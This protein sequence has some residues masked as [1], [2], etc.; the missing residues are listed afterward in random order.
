MWILMWFYMW[1]TA[2]AHYYLIK[3][4][5]QADRIHFI[6]DDDSTIESSIFKVFSDKF[7]EEKALYFTC[8]YEKNLTLE[9]AGKKTFQSR[10]HLKEWAKT[11]SINKAGI[12]EIA[13]EKL[14]SDLS[15]HEFY[16]RQVAPDGLR[17]YTRG[18]NPIQHPL[19]DK[20]EGIRWVNLI[21]HVEFIQQN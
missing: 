11:K 4:S 9:E 12:G 15:G 8:Q 7:K 21:N 10:N 1:Y 13:R 14:E 5:V 3:E 17:H 16:E 18:H 19:P 2:I 20:D 6:S